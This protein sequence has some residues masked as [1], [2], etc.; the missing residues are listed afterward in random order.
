[1][2]GRQTVTFGAVGD[3]MLCRSV[4]RDMRRHGPGWPLEKMLPTLRQ[5]DV[6]FGNMESVVL[7]PDYPDAEIDLQG[8]VDKYD[9]TAALKEAGFD[10]MNLAANHALDGGTLGMFHTKSVLEGQG[11]AAGGVGRSQRE[12]R[13]LVVLEKAGLRWGFLGYCE[14]SNYSL[15]AAGPGYAY[16]APRTVL[17]DIRRHRASVDVLVV[18]IHADLEFMETPCP[19]RRDA[20]RA[21]ADAGATFVL[22]HHPHV[23][24]G[25]ELRG[26]SLIAYSLGNFCFDAHSSRYMRDHGPGTAL[27]FVL[28]AEVSRKGVE[29]FRRVPLRIGEPPRERPAPLTGAAATK[30][31]AYFDE[32]DRKLDDDAFLREHWRKRAMQVLAYNLRLLRG[33]EEEEAA[34]HLLGKSLFVAENRSWATEVLRA[35]KDHWRRGRGRIDRLHRPSYAFAGLLSP[36]RPAAGIGKGSRR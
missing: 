33:V 19:A 16:Y 21:F 12:A 28:L 23:P 15:S 32:L 5:A 31:R 8:L 36:R 17:A 34:L 4:A 25:I 10:Y 9:G 24:Q 29:S 27:S 11:I 35:L 30:L 13:K 14:D 18:S 1:M 2:A 6:L 3:I 22:M 26:G 20:G 7:P